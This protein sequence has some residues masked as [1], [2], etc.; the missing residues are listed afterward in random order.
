MIPGSYAYNVPTIGGGNSNGCVP[1][2]D[3]GSIYMLYQPEISW[4]QE[5][6]PCRN[7]NSGQS[8]SDCVLVT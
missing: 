3:T 5:Q 1:L 7:C 8:E 6:R 4:E 2:D